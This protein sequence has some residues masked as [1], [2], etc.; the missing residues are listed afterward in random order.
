[1][2]DYN[3]DSNC[4]NKLMPHPS[5]CVRVSAVCHHRP[6]LREQ[7]RKEKKETDA[8]CPASCVVIKKK[9]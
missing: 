5:L 4:T 7:K 6:F 8:T 9:R 2:H 3:R 1:M